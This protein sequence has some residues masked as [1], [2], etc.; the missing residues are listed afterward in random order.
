MPNLEQF[1]GLRVLVVE[2]YPM[3]QKVARLQLQ[4]LGCL[5]DVVSS[6]PEALAALECHEYHIVLMDCEMPGMDGYTAAAEIR[7]REAG[8]RRTTII[9]MT[10][11]AL[12]SRRQRSLDAGMDDHIVKPVTLSTLGAVLKRWTQKKAPSPLQLSA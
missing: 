7:R 10:G 3:C 9:A 5:P 1:S 11:H 2:D 4:S 8:A 6:G 12:E